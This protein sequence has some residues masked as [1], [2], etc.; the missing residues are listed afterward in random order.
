MGTVFRMK[1]PEL[2]MH[3]CCTDG[4]HMLCSHPG[5]GWATVI[6]MLNQDECWSH[7]RVDTVEAHCYIRWQIDLEHNM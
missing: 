6:H 3:A 2:G 4:A 5:L 7:V 1:P